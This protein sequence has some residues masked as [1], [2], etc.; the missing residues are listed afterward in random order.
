MRSMCGV[1]AHGKVGSDD[2]LGKCSNRNP[3]HTGVRQCAKT[4]Q[5]YAP[6][7]L[8]NRPTRIDR[9]GLTQRRQIH[10][11]QQH[12]FGAAFKRL[13]QLVKRFHFDFDKISYASNACC[14]CKHLRYPSG[15]CN[16]VFL[17]KDRVIQTNPM[18][19]STTGENCIFL[20][21]S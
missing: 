13:S 4:F 6:R 3:I 21:Q 2:I 11:V 20:S 5:S 16:V 8:Q 19:G 7:N 14:L 9:N 12:H 1:K 15:R 18:I 17:D 10:I